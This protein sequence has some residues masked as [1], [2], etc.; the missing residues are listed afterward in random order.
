M[1]G[2]HFENREMLLLLAIMIFK[3]GKRLR[4]EFALVPLAAGESNQRW[5][6]S[7]LHPC[8]LNWAQIWQNY[9]TCFCLNSL[10]RSCC[11]YNT[12]DS[13]IDKTVIW[14]LWWTH[15]DF[16]RK[17]HSESLLSKIVKSLA[18]GMSHVPHFIHHIIQGD[19]VVPHGLKRRSPIY[20]TATESLD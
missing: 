9:Q 8:L 11:W 18:P 19:D 7:L 17:K 3:H 16:E 2:K 4:G 1:R 5:D 20:R 14:W 15:T 12:S 6:V 10:E 13:E